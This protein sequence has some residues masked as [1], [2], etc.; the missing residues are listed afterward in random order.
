MFV[1]NS[2][3]H[4]RWCCGVVWCT[5]MNKTKTCR[6]TY[7][8][9]KHKQAISCKSEQK[10]KQKIAVNKLRNYKEIFWRNFIVKCNVQTITNNLRILCTTTLLRKFNKTHNFAWTHLM[11]LWPMFQCCILQYFEFLFSILCISLAAFFMGENARNS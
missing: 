10:V 5:L 6:F 1:C 2:L 4:S 8:S 7:L 3:I 9:L 11:T